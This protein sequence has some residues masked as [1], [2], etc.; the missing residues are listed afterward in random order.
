MKNTTTITTEFIKKMSVNDIKDMNEFSS[1][2]NYQYVLYSLTN[3]EGK[4]NGIA[5]ISTSRTMNAHCMRYRK[6]ENSICASCY[7]SD[8]EY[9]TDLFKKLDKNHVFYT[10]HRIPLN[11]IPL[12]PYMF[13]RFESFADL[14]NTIQVWNYFMIANKNNHANTALWTKNPWIIKNAMNWYNLKKPGNMQ[15]IYSYLFK[16]GDRVEDIE[17]HFQLVKKA[18]PFIDKMFVVYD[19][20]YAE[21]HN[22]D[23]NCEMSCLTCQKCYTENDITIIN[24][25][26]K[27]TVMKAV[28]KLAD[29][30]LERDI[31]ENAILE[32]ENYLIKPRTIYRIE[33]HNY[34]YELVVIA[35]KRKGVPF[36]GNG[37]YMLTDID[38]VN[39]LIELS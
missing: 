13:I 1:M 21:K 11:D 10:S 30:E 36:I 4:L 26:D 2:F 19:Q 32:N 9:K 6:I 8:H 35:K 29:V 16:N 5:S 7:V 14:V 28:Y 25:R 39:R 20:E 15:I 34:K 38:H 24:E 22:I 3:H 37:H 33:K 18:Y 12:I 23:I 31:I 27:H 17:R